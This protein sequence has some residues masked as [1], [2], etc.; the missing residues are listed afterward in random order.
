MARGSTEIQ[1]QGQHVKRWAPNKS[2]RFL[3]LSQSLAPTDRKW[4]IWKLGKRYE[5]LSKGAN[6]KGL[7]CKK[8]PERGRGPPRDDEGPFRLT[9]TSML[10]TRNNKKH[11]R[12]Q[13]VFLSNSSPAKKRSPLS[14]LPRIQTMES[15]SI[16]PSGWT[17]WLAP[18]EICLHEKQ[19]LLRLRPNAVS[20]SR[21]KR[22][23]TTRSGTANTC[24]PNNS[25][26]FQHILFITSKVPHHCKQNWIVIGC[27]CQIKPFMLLFIYSNL[28]HGHTHTANQCQVFHI[29]QTVANYVK[30]LGP[31]S[32]RKLRGKITTY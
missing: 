31:W 28:E 20:N 17:R 25:Y 29:L 6:Q 2:W 15:D 4:R 30:S 21:S 32:T 26:F 5:V 1:I 10:H 11:K 13:L 14:T 8:G 7:L 12:V 27:E 16:N 24:G 9:T 3:L 23:H 18:N 19:S 22:K